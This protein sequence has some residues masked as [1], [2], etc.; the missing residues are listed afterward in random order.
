M[1]SKFNP[2]SLKSHLIMK[3]QEATD[4]AGNVYYYN[5]ETN[6]TQWEKPDEEESEWVTYTTDDGQEYYYNTKTKETT[7]EKPEEK[8]EPDNEEDEQLAKQE[9]LKD[10]LVEPL[11]YGPEVAVEKFKKLLEEH[12]VDTTWSFERVIKEL[13]SESVYWSVADAS[14][15]RRIYEEFLMQ[16]IQK[17]SSSKA[18]LIET[19]RKNFRLVLD[20]YRELGKMKLTTRWMLVKKALIAEDNPIFKHSALSDKDF[21][22]LFDV[23]IAELKREHQDK[24]EAQRDVALAELKVC[25]LQVGAQLDPK[26]LL[27]ELL[28]EKLQADARFKSIKHVE[29]LTK[30]DIIRE[31]QESVLPKALR[32]LQEQLQSVS[33]ENYRRDRKARQAFKALLATMSISASLRFE[34]FYATLEREDSFIEICGRAGLTPVE[35]FMDVVEKEKVRLKEKKDM[36]EELLASRDD[37]EQLLRDAKKFQDALSTSGKEQLANLG[38][39]VRKLLKSEFEELRKLAIAAKEKELALAIAVL[40]LWLADNQSSVPSLSSGLVELVKK[41]LEGKPAYVGL[42]NLAENIDDAV[43]LSM[44]RA[45][46]TLKERAK[47]RPSEAPAKP[48]KRQAMMNY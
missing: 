17:E 43:R 13:V 15:R 36:A 19:F 29:V 37:Y 11:Y 46:S 18:D 44:A 10:K 5:V 6:E 22:G 24:L 7:W 48:A 20:S 42:L 9:V 23:Y 27:W 16:K 2:E 34:D 40:G 30:L 14:E 21:E 38:D 32:G 8:T 3:W 45:E 28:Y 33:K 41:E 25:I 47:K 31:Y 4:E 12:G 35:L 1:G 39:D 26:L